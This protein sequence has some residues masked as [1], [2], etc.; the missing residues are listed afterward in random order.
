MRRLVVF[1]LLFISLF[2]TSCYRTLYTHEQEMD[3]YNTKNSIIERFGIP[4]KKERSGDYEQW[5]Y[6]YGTVTSG[7]SYSS[8]RS[9]NTQIRPN[10]EGIGIRSTTS[11]SFRN[12]YSQTNSRYVRFLIKGNRV[13]SYETYG[14][15]F[16]VQEPNRTGNIWLG[17]IFVGTL[18]F[19]I[20]MGISA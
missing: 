14:V 7:T 2:T 8:Q 16:S 6:D 20:I 13:V 19:A 17:L 12:D 10:Q 11:P 15:D 3:K 9:T 1:S 18:V 5:I 4:S